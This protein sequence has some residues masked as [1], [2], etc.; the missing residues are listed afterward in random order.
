[1]GNEGD[2]QLSTLLLKLRKHLFWVVNVDQF[3][4]YPT[5]MLI[6]HLQT[7]RPGSVLSPNLS[8]GFNDSTLDLLNNAFTIQARLCTDLHRHRPR[9][10]RLSLVNAWQPHITRAV[11]QNG[12]GHLA[13]TQGPCTA[14]PP[15]ASTLLTPVT[16]SQGLYLQG[17]LVQHLRQ[18]TA[19]SIK[20][21]VCCCKAQP[22][23]G[24]CTWS[25]KAHK[26]DLNTEFASLAFCPYTCVP[27][28][29]AHPMQSAETALMG[30]A[31][32]LQARHSAS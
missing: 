31:T 10:R 30:Y 11:E 28:M 3:L 24:S 13:L 25:P 2:E 32:A 1:M 21:S 23:P 14:Q 22:R 26:T 12:T 15:E 7:Y 20:Q 8:V 9:S 5:L 17:A 16:P 27:V 6:L 4:L 18:S 19:H 29:V